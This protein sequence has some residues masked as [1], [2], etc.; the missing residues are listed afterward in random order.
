M[1][2]GWMNLPARYALESARDEIGADLH[3]IE[4]RQFQAA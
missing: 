3:E 4:T 1:P 2:E